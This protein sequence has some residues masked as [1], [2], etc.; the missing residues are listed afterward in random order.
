MG[1]NSTLTCIAF[2]EEINYS[3]YFKKQGGDDK[4]ITAITIGSDMY[5][6]QK[7]PIKFTASSIEGKKVRLVSEVK[8]G[9]EYIFKEW[10]ITNSDGKTVT[11]TS[12]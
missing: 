6:P 1:R 9:S 12:N 8:D 5:T 4:C 3:F 7:E 11:I 2:F 10:R